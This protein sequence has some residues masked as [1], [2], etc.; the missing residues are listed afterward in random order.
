MLSTTLEINHRVQSRI[1]LQAPAALLHWTESLIPTEKTPV[2][3]HSR[4]V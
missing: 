3:H 1:E 2:R 4:Y